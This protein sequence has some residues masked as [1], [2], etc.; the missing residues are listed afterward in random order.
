MKEEVWQSFVKEKGPWIEKNLS[1]IPRRKEYQYTEGEIHYLLGRTVTLHVDKGA[2]NRCIIRDDEA[3]LTYRRENSDRRKILAACWEEELKAVLAL[4]IQQWAPVM[5][6]QP[7]GFGINC[8]KSRWG[9]CN[10][11]TGELRFSLEL[12]AKPVACI[13]SVVVHELTH[14]LEPT[15]N[16]RFHHFMDHWLPDWKERKKKLNAFP[17]EFI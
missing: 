11:C 4:L 6:V 5:H 1:R 16:A 17:R 3:W 12:A 9:S 8:T 14:L 7:S 10:T 13:E 2:E 15:H